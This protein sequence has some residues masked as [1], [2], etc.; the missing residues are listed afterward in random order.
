MLL[1]YNYVKD[2]AV[3]LYETVAIIFEWLYSI[4]TLL[5]SCISSLGQII[6]WMPSVITIAVTALVAI[7]VLYKVLGREGS[8]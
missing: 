2:F 5:I 6:I 1:I 8:N 7:T 4:I 3:F